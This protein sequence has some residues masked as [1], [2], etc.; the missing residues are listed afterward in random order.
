MKTVDIALDRDEISKK[1]FRELSL[2]LVASCYVYL[3]NILIPPS[4][5]DKISVISIFVA[6]VLMTIALWRFSC[7][8]VFNLEE[9]KGSHVLAKSEGAVMFETEGQGGSSSATKTPNINFNFFMPRF[10]TNFI[11]NET[12]INNYNTYKTYIQKVI[13][14]KKE[15]SV[16]DQK[17]KRETAVRLNLANKFTVD[18]MNAYLIRKE[19]MSV[20]LSNIEIYSNNQKEKVYTPVDV[21]EKITNDELML[22]GWTMYKYLNV[23]SR[24]EA[25]FFIKNVFS[26]KFADV[27][28]IATI[29]R[30]L[31]RLK[32]SNF[33][34][35]KKKEDIEKEVKDALKDYK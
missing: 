13:A 35:I 34:E 6:I 7:L 32:T 16:A 18:N 33:I 25:A 26:K 31:S 30:N 15:N 11:L 19:D 21:Y 14:D 28:N 23:L 4:T 24:Y 8:V 29:A 22:Y 27:D 2:S 1:I 10:Y 17:I 20:L 5:P 12:I 3:Q 9:K